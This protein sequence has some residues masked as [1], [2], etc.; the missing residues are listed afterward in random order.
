VDK[1]LQGAPAN[2]L[3]ELEQTGI[4]LQA[5]GNNVNNVGVVLTRLCE[6]DTATGRA[7]GDLL[8]QAPEPGR[9]QFLAAVMA[10]LAV[11]DPVHAADLGN[12][13]LDTRVQSKAIAT[14]VALFNPRWNWDDTALR[15]VFDRLLAHPDPHVRA[16]A[17]RRLHFVKQDHPAEVVA[18][19]L[20][21]DMDGEDT[22]AAVADVLTS[23]S[24]P[25]HILTGDSDI[26]RLLA[27][28]ERLPGFG[29]YQIPE[30]M[31][32]LG[33]THP[34]HV[35]TFL[36]RRAAHAARRQPGDDWIDTVPLEWT[37]DAQAEDPA[38]RADALRTIRD[39]STDL[40]RIEDRAVIFAAIAGGFGDTTM[41]VLHE[42]LASPTEQ[43]V[44]RAADLLGGAS[45]TVVLDQQPFV[46]ELLDT[47]SSLSGDIADRIQ[48]Q[49]AGTTTG[50]YAILTFADGAAMDAQIRDRA[51]QIAQTLPVGRARSL[52]DDVASRAQARVDEEE[53]REQ[54]LRDLRPWG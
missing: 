19:A 37:L 11:T 15:G 7:L 32:R 23:S 49:L 43:S 44:Q 41:T 24:A 35:A 40:I 46:I 2:V 12:A 14:A 51:Q 9:A 50:T 26:D 16:L 53:R 36:L 10:G 20:G 48:H 27:M 42:L 52:Y 18:L 29:D 45:R 8:L 28:W 21:V 33:H 22:A 4:A 3:V 38:R 6:R 54:L 31:R 13:A 39:Q 34:E 25:G 17:L 47:A 5:A 30:L 1:L